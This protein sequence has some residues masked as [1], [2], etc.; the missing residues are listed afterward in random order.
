MTSPE[1]T[2]AEYLPIH[3]KQIGLDLLSGV[4]DADFVEMNIPASLVIQK[5]QMETRS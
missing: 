4:P 1:I 5:H 2:V 3:I